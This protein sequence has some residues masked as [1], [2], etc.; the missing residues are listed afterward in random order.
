MTNKN[1]SAARQADLAWM[2]DEYKR[3]E[4]LLRQTFGQPV[5]PAVY[6]DS[7]FHGDTTAGRVVVWTQ[8]SR[9]QRI[10]V[11]RSTAAML[12]ACARRRDAAVAP[13]SFFRDIR[14]KSLLRQLHALTV[15][16]DGVAFADLMALIHHGFMGLVPTYAVNSGRGLH[17]VYLFDVPV[18]TYDWSKALLDQMLRSLKK[19]FDSIWLSYD[20]DQKPGII[21]IY[22]IVG[23]RTKLGTTCSAYRSGTP[24]TVDGLAAALGVT[25]CR[26]QPRQQ[27]SGWIHD[28]DTVYTLPNGRASFYTCVRDGIIERTTRGHRHLAL[29]ALGVVAAKCRVPAGVLAADAARV[30]AAFNARDPHDP[31]PTRDVTKALASVDPRRA[32]TVKASTLEGWLGW[33]FERKTKRNGRSRQEHLTQVAHVASA[34]ARSGRARDAVAAYVAAHPDTTV[35]A[36]A[37]ALG[38]SRT[39]IT[40]YMKEMKEAADKEADFFSHFVTVIPAR[41]QTQTSTP[42]PAPQ[43]PATPTH[44]VGIDADAVQRQRDLAAIVATIMDPTIDGRTR[45]RLLAM[46]PPGRREIVA[47]WLSGS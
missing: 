19:R 44:P 5:D 4:C 32:K 43:P 24:Y 45:T 13:C 37:A 35:T 17:L 20:V 18:E 27:A 30:Q 46:L 34:A 23:S 1:E 6:N 11:Y 33:S 21:Q 29:F 16:L 2:R 47:G 9:G 14:H 38:M 31:I 3:K 39:T 10:H 42:T 40:K 22:R 8:A 26:P 12:D 36:A 28:S 7:L 15:D 41:P 25:W